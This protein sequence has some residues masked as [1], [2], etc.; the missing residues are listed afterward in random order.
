M[1]N[2]YLFN[3]FFKIKILTKHFII[4][5]VNNDALKFA[6]EKKEAWISVLAIFFV[7]NFFFIE[8]I[9][10]KYLFI[11]KSQIKP[12]SLWIDISLYF[13]L[14]MAIIGIL[15]VFVWDNI[16]TDKTDL[17]NIIHLPITKSE[18]F[19]SKILSI[20]VLC[21][22]V[23][24]ILNLLS[25]ISFVH[26]FSDI[27][28]INFF[29]YIFVHFIIAF[30]SALFVFFMIAVLQSIIKVI[31]KGE[32]LRVVSSIV[33]IILLIIFIT[34]IIE[35]P[36]LTESL[37]Q[38]KAENSNLLYY[39]PFLWF[40]GLHQYAIGR[41]EPIFIC[42]AKYALSGFIILFVFYVLSLPL[43][44]K[45]LLDMNQE[46]TKTI[47][48]S[49]FKKKINSLFQTLF[50]RSG[51]QRA[52][53]FFISNIFKKEPKLKFKLVFILVFPVV[54][55]ISKIILKYWQIGQK[56]FNELQPILIV[57]PGFFFLFLIIGLKFVFSTSV[58]LKANWIFR[59]VLTFNDI[60][61]INAIIKK[62]I[63]FN[64]IFPISCGLSVLY[65]FCWGGKLS[66]FHTIFG[67]F[68]A[69]IIIEITFYKF[70]KIPFTT[71]PIPGKFKLKSLWFVYLFSLFIYII[72]FIKLSLFLLKNPVYYI[73][74]YIFIVIFIFCLRIMQARKN[75]YNKTL[76]FDEEPQ[77]YFI[78]FSLFE[79]N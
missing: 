42:Q 54:S 67:V 79:Q 52:I 35:L 62:F 16:F 12:D 18:L 20:I 1:K 43:G 58:N 46:K 17:L 64:F 31:F 72:S 13:T 26:Y 47:Q 73:P 39:F 60:K 14:S 61:Q 21:G 77:P 70:N 55:I 41:I 57:I 29:K 19:L 53:Y 56:F 69:I 65:F 51:I 9:L 40:S 7:V 23:S 11:P 15:V 63:L 22:L 6:T 33:K 25:V 48:Y 4:R 50:L 5:Y 3:F 74:V 2:T 49:N 34:M 32:H 30:L 37:K 68:T 24:I 76:N 78:D 66:V 28:K 71:E 75:D 10:S 8:N 27:F 59:N 38:L 45:Q 36:L 44:I